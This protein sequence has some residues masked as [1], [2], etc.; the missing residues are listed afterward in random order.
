LASA[1]APP[2][3]IDEGR[4]ALRVGLAAQESLRTG[5]PVRL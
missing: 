1:K 3:P 4:A 2:I 5:L